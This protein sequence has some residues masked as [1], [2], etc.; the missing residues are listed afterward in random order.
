MVTKRFTVT[1]GA[2]DLHVA[3][4]RGPGSPVVIVHGLAGSSSEMTATANAL[5]DHRVVTFDARGHGRST[6]RP[7]DVSREAHV[8]DVVQ[9]I[10]T[11]IGEPVTLVGQSM[12]GHTALLVASARPDLVQRLVLLEAGVGGDGTEQSRQGMRQFF[13]SWP[14]PFADMAHAQSV[15]GDSSIGRAWAADL[16]KRAD[17]LWP[18]F[19]PDIII[20]TIAQVDAQ[21]RWDEWA[22]ID[23]P[24][25]VVF[26]KEGMFDPGMREE[27]VSRGQQV[28]RLDLD[29][30]SHDA[31][32]DAFPQWIEALTIFLENSLRAQRR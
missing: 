1:R 29:Q 2:V 24:T 19:D 26:G 22:L 8:A 15:L 17:G 31:H 32:L 4:R 16:E 11:V 14:A 7:D 30:G 28:D 6:R 18:R 5:A 3:D 13:E 12:G 25:L 9:L 10:E 23:L 20:A 27:L 21:A